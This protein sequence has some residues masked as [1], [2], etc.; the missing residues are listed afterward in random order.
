[1]LS[2]L[3]HAFSTECFLLN[4]QALYIS[5]KNYIAFEKESAV[6]ETILHLLKYSDSFAHVHEC[7]KSTPSSLFQ[8]RCHTVSNLLQ[9]GMQGFHGGGGDALKDILRNV[10]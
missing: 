6:F 9:T 2:S 5:V 1:M 8:G 10:G 7:R 4:V 3:A